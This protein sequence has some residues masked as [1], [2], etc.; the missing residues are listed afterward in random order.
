M[1]K[2]PLMLAVILM[3]SLAACAKT[4]VLPEAAISTEDQ[5]TAIPQKAVR[6]IPILAINTGDPSKGMVYLEDPATG[7]R[8]P[9]LELADLYSDHYHPVEYQAGNLFAIRRFDYTGPGDDDWRSELWV[10]DA[11]KNGKMVFASKTLDFRASPDG[12]TIAVSDND[13]LFF[14]DT[15]GN[16]FAQLSAAQLGNGLPGIENASI[17]LEGWSDD[18]SRFWGNLFMASELLGFYEANAIGGEIKSYDILAVPFSRQEYA[19]NLT[20]G[21]L[22]FSDYPRFF[23]ADSAERFKASSSTVTL[24]LLDLPSMQLTTIAINTAKEFHPRWLGN[25]G[26]QYDDPNAPDKQLEYALK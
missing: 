25:N 14:M 15:N 7:E 21:K 18:G 23:D 2:R 12:M 6:Y 8:S 16:A 3:T 26:I 22:V 17:D 20:T 19:L 1:N 24:Y 9:Y 5:Q 11:A 10:Y 13:R 4:P